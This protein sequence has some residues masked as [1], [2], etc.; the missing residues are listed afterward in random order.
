MPSSV[1]RTNY[2][3][4]TSPR[5]ELSD[6]GLTPVDVINKHS[7]FGRSPQSATSPTNP[8]SLSH[9][10]YAV[11]QDHTSIS[12]SS[13]HHLIS[14]PA[15]E[16]RPD[17]PPLGGASGVG[18]AADGGRTTATGA[19]QPARLVSGVSNLSEHE[20]SHLRHISDTSVSSAAATFTGE[21]APR[22]G[23][24]SPTLLSPMQEPPHNS[25]KLSPPL[26]VSPP[27]GDEREAADYLSVHGR[28]LTSQVNA[29]NT[30]NT[31][32][33]ASPLRRSVFYESADDLGESY[34]QQQQNQQPSHR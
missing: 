20:A 12:S 14:G 29:P 2:S 4:D 22:S 18:A 6:T 1:I 8:S 10:H 9:S 34:R 16:D 19:Q 24:A 17:S 13:A 23:A 27:T 5:A 25:G 21:G 26:P 7:H 11:S 32:S 3:L 31:T 30:A 33:I 28:S 15:S